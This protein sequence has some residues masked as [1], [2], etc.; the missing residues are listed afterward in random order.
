[1]N[2]IQAE[3]YLLSLSNIPRQEYMDTKKKTDHYLKRIQ[4][5][6]DL[7]GNPEKKI[8]HYIHVTGTSGKGSVST[9]LSFI[10][11]A[12]GKR[13]GLTISPHPTTL[14]ERWQINNKIMSE[15][16]FI[17]IVEQLKPA[18]DKYAQTSPYDMVS[19]FD[20]TT[21]IA[22]L[23]FAKQK[24]EWAVMEVGCGGRLDS[25]NIIPYK[26]IA[27]ITNIGLD[28]T[29]ILGDTKEKIAFEK[30]G[31]ITKKCQVFTM[32]EDPSVLSVIKKT[33]KQKNVDLN[34]V[35]NL[36]RDPQALTKKFGIS[37]HHLL[38]NALFCEKIALHLKLPKNAIE[39][40]IKKAKQPLRMEIVSQHPLI[41]LDG[42]HNEDKMKTTV[43]ATQNLQKKNIH[44]I[45]GFSNDKDISVMIKQLASL[46]P[47]T[48]A[49]TRQ[50]VNPFRK[51]ALPKQIEKLFQ[52]YSA[53]SKTKIFLDP[54]EA[55]G[56]SKK[57]TKTDDVLLVTG[58][59][60]LSGE[61]K[62]LL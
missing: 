14:R 33:C 27:V 41:I 40:G 22:L 32:E 2:Y 35:H 48:I 12:A 19:F 21:T 10:L 58:S 50:T 61:I 17:A 57:Q 23:Y 26:D 54:G 38:Q 47:K 25:T 43:Q 16:D 29:E 18:L 11:Q 7:L 45:V 1:M 13:V 28:H 60:F 24:V 44:L 34:I 62:T 31:I 15:K 6:L 37:S 8:P 46:K 4:F 52:K 55:F 56:W 53:H 9:F 42:A 5:L 59:I 3:Q 39:K 30:A 20:L 36:V 51:V 49:C